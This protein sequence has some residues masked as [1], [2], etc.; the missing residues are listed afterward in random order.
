MKNFGAIDRKWQKKWG[1]GNVFSS[2]QITEKP[3]YYVL[4]MF[5]YPSG[6]IHVGHLRNYAMGDVIA[7]FYRASGYNVLYPMGWDAF[8][9]PA[10][11]AAILNN[12]HPATWTYSNIES[13]KAQIKTTG[14]SYDWSREIATCDPSYYKHEQEFFINL[15][16][17]NLAYQQESVVNWD[18]VDNTVLAN[19]QVIDGRGWRSGALVEKRNLKQWFLRITNYAEELLEETYNLRGWPE[20][21]RTMQQNWIG[22]SVGA[23]IKFRIKGQDEFLEVYSTRPDTLFGC[24]FI[25]ICYNHNLVDKANKTDD[26]EHFIDNCK[27]MSTATAEIERAEKEGVIL[28][29]VA[30]HPFDESIEIPIYIA[31]YVLKDYGS[32]AV[33]GCPAH[34][35]RDWI[36]AKKYNIEIKQ[37]LTGPN[38][39]LNEAIDINIAPFLEDG[40]MMNSDFLN[41]LDSASAKQKAIEK[42]EELARGKGKICYRLRDWGVSRQRYWGCPIPMIYCNACGIVPEKIENLPVELPKDVDFTVPGNPLDN[43]PTWKHTSCP[44]CQ[45]PAL[46]E[47]D[48]FDTFFESSWY[49]GRFC[50]TDAPKMLSKEDANYWLPVDKYIGGIEHA[51]L[52][53]LYARFFTKA[54]NDEGLLD[55]RE[56]F[57]NLLTQ[58]MVLHAA[59]KDESGAW[60]Y[61][62][63][64]IKTD[65]GLLHKITGEKISQL[66]VEK[67]SKSKKNV[68]DLERIMEK[69][70]ADTVRL[71]ILS[72]SPPERDLE[73]SDQGVEGCT[74]FIVRLYNY[75]EWLINAK[76]QGQEDLALTAKTHQTIKAVSLDIK[77]A[78]FN[79][80]IARIRELFNLL[81]EKTSAAQNQNIASI[82]YLHAFESVIRL[83]NPFCPHTTE[84]IWEILGHKI[85]LAINDWPKY[86]ETLAAPSSV[87][88]AVQINGKLKATIEAPLDSGREFLEKSIESDGLIAKHLEGAT[89]LKTIFV[90]NKII[91]F[92]IK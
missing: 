36:F 69:Y 65:K 80:A 32:G 22:K 50:N 18:P 20:S 90:P 41:G 45:K 62:E 85:L 31:N 39:G 87:V 75:A 9:L 53:L 26:I 68:V 4:E 2:E 71:F 40:I 47:T 72:D 54:M 73:W 7:R 60:V 91:N 13:M 6:K 63:E 58:G 76:I 11:N 88:I 78:H 34:D 48:T 49:F 79:K 17:K 1:D 16:N 15:Y 77:D 70:G 74:K 27:K 51:V 82:S 86:E 19:E 21:V 92:V 44:K 25:A 42:L 67:M 57:A 29:L 10:E 5:P 33:F 3:K 66:K 38:T 64:V 59:Y 83:L 52:H 28:D 84:E 35:E 30:L 56:P 81:S 8:G 14:N 37:V 61:P 12:T 23:N 43:H 24:T 89:V 46:R 55:A